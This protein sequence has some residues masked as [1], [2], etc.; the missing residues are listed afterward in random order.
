MTKKLILLPFLL[1]SQTLLAG[2]NTGGMDGGGGGTLPAHPA[3]VY[4]IQDIAQEAKPQLLYLLNGYEWREKYD[5]QKYDQQKPLYRKL[6]SGPRKAQEVLKD[7]RLEV[8][9]DKPC[10][11]SGGIEVDGSIYA[12][13]SNTICLSAF[14]I[15]QKIDKAAAEREV[16]ALLMHEVSHFMGT[17]EDEAVDLQKDISWWILNAKAGS[18]LD[19]ASLR[20]E[21]DGFESLL[22]YSIE[23]LDQSDLSKANEQLSKSLVRL[24]RWEGMTNSSPYKLFEP[25]EEQY[26]DLLRLKLIWA[27]NYIEALIPGADQSWAVDQYNKIFNGREFF[28]AHEDMGW[29]KEHLYRDEKVQRLHSLAELK[30]LLLTLKSDYEIRS[31]YNYQVTFGMR[32]MHLNG[33]LTVP[34]RNPWQNFVGQYVVQSV[35]CDSPSTREN[36]VEFRVENTAAGL[37]L[38]N[39]FSS[40]SMANRIEF[41]AYNVNAYLNNYGETTDGGVFMIHEMGGSWSTRDFADTQIS[42]F[43]LKKVSGNNFEITRTNSYLPKDVTKPDS[44]RTCVFKGVIQ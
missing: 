22:G 32:W 41:G 18:Q 20:N 15:S 44:I 9:L 25:R 8:R 29:D 1:I 38:R 17:T 27:N 34:T 3:S 39:I 43:R 4:E 23:A 10:L 13:K 6:F 2:G 28:L 21:F 19:E 40:A 33:H 36:E 12:L 14:R 31:A 35:Q 37:Y 5:Q 24:T 16:L 42:D 11:T 7:L 26:Q 30:D